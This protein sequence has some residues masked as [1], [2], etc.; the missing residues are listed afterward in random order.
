MPTLAILTHELSVLVSSWL[1]RLWLIAAAVTTFL[2]V[3]GNWNRL[4]SAL[5]IAMALVTYLVFP[6]FFV[7]IGAMALV[8]GLLRNIPGAPFDWLAPPG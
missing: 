8:F 7:V 6:W 3:A 2:V 1:V 4:D 5:L